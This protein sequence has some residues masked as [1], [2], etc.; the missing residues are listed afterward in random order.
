MTIAEGIQAIRWS[1]FHQ[2]LL[3]VPQLAQWLSSGT[4]CARSDTPASFAGPG[5]AERLMGAR[6]PLRGTPGGGTP[7]SACGSLAR[8]GVGRPRGLG[9]LSDQL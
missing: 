1:R 6:R 4:G 2:G 8:G 7:W 9:N 3:S 5:A